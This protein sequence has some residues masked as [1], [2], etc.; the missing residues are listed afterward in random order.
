MSA[1]D[2]LILGLIRNKAM[3]A[4]ELAEMSGIYEL[5]KLSKPA[6]YRNIKLLEKRGYLEGERRKDGNMPEKRIYR[7]SEKGLEYQGQLMDSL[8]DEP[9]KLHF[10]FN[11]VLFLIEQMPREQ[12]ISRLDSLKLK[13]QI[14]LQRLIEEESRYAHLSVPVAALVDQHIRLTRTLLE[15]L[16]EFIDKFRK[17]GS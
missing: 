2:L 10:D 6:V 8:I 16:T 4:Y 13:L 5:L 9:I 12:A 11:A 1:V 3:S 17:I 14:N 15:W 7:V